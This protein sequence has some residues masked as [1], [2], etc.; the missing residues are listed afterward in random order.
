MIKNIVFDLGNVLMEYN[1]QKYLGKFKF[2]EKTKQILYKVIF[3]SND[4]IEYDRGIYRHNTDLIKKIVKENPNLENEIKLVLQKDWVKMNSI[5][6]NTVKFLKDLKNQGYKIYILSNIS[7]D[8]YKFVSQ[9]DFFDFVDG[10]VYSYELHICKPNKEIYKKLLDK[11]NLE[12]K[13]TIFID[14]M[15]PNIKSANELGINGV[16]FTTLDEVKQKVKL[17]IDKK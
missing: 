3:Q 11:Y 1:P 12:P 9:Y 4:W 5:K 13:D 7:G 8:S 10:G 2:D 16:Q 6:E 14:D 17:L 15:L